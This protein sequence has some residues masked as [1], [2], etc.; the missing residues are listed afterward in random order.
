MFRYLVV[1]LV[2]VLALSGLVAGWQAFDMLTDD[3]YIAFRYVSNSL[4]GYGYTWNPPPFQP[5]EG[6][7]S[8]LWVVLLD[9]IWRV[10][11]IEPPDSANVVL[12]LFSIGT[13][14]VTVGMVLRLPLAPALAPSRPALLALVLAGTVGNRTFLAWTS[15]GLETGMFNFWLTLWTFLALFVPDHYPTRR[16]GLA[17]VA[18]LAAL[19]RPDGLL[20]A[21]ATLL[22][23]AWE[24]WRRGHHSGRRESWAPLLAL[25]AIPLHLWWRHA[26]Y[27]QWLPNTYFA[28][29][30]GLW[31]EAGGRYLLSFVLEYALVFWLLLAGLW[32]VDRARHRTEEVARVESARRW[33][34]GSGPRAA[35]VVAALLAH[36]AYYLVVIGGDHFEYRVLSQLVP[37]IFVSALYLLNGL[38]W[39]RAGALAFLA[40]FVATSLP[41]PWVHWARSQTRTS[42]AEAARMKV[43]VSDAF[44]A[45]LGS[46]TRL[47]D[48]TQAWLIE[49]MICVRH[50]EH[51][52]FWWQQ[53]ADSPSRKEG[54]A[55]PS[56][57]F[58]IA[59]GGTVGVP[60]WVLPR[61][62]ILDL[63]GLNDRVVARN[64][65]LRGTRRTMAHD[66]QPPP[67]YVECF[68]PNFDWTKRP[69][70][71]LRRRRPLDAQEIRECERRFWEQMQT[72][73]RML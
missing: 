17:G 67:G 29:N 23:L 62:N 53:L 30:A 3:A 18:S 48:A 56:T 33:L 21:A 34:R 50:R 40:V 45:W 39:R 14:L 13:V 24:T 44:P 47:F 12:L 8:F 66:R 11:G 73:P 26:K 6:Y 31:P 1:V 7:T 43:A 58:P 41:I 9:G 37:L 51:Q 71:V 16:W 42:R 69:L 25:G 72:P 60:S 55:L 64:P 10:T 63:L 49:R 20:F 46:Y 32:L 27:G 59:A 15:S 70:S 4:L 28:K 57:D 54:L 38:R 35:L 52:L 36:V 65:H 68:R 61:V 2:T 22:L 5:V 19:T